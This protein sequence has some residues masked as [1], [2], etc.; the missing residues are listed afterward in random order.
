MLNIAQITNIK[1]HKDDLRVSVQYLGRYKDDEVCLLTFLSLHFLQKIQCHLYM[2]R[3][4]DQISSDMLEGVCYLQ[5][6]TNVEAIKH[7]VSHDDHFYL[8]QEQDDHGNLS[9]L[10]PGKF[11]FCQICQDGQKQ[12]IKDVE[13]FFQQNSKLIGMELFSGKLS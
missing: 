1:K 3:K 6:L 10:K 9:L 12:V 8:N 13:C 4:R 7:W 5:Y 11:R 2:S